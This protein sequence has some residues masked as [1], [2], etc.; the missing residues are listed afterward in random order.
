MIAVDT[1]ILAFAVNRHAR[2]HARAAGLVDELCNG[3]TPWALP[4]PAVD[5]FVR[6]VTGAHVAPRPL[7]PSDALEFVEALLESASVTA[8]GPTDRHAAVLA[9][10]ASDAA[11]VGMLPPGFEIAAVLREHG[12]RE[13]LTTDAGMRRFGFL[14]VIDPVHGPPWSPETA[15]ARRYRRLSAPEI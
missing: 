11:R 4:W 12:V 5:E 8:L 15:P 1:S 2:E 10:L 14:T 13:L 9:G 7:A 6:F 3:D